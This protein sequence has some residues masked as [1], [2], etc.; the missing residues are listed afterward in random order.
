[1]FFVLGNYAIIIIIAFPTSFS[2]SLISYL[3]RI[4]NLYILLVCEYMQYYPFINMANNICSSSTIFLIKKMKYFQTDE[5]II[6]NKIIV[7]EVFS[8][9]KFR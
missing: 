3:I 1:M 2:Y 9:K 4:F 5:C 8:E 6:V 7:S